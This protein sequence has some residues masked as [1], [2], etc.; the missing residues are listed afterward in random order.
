MTFH[1]SLINS[2]KFPVRFL[3][4]I[5][6]RDQR[7]V[8]GRVLS[9]ISRICGRDLTSLST[10]VAKDKIKYAVAPVS[11]KWRLGLAKEL[12]AARNSNEV[13][14]IGFTADEKEEMLRHVCVD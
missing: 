12:L 3:A 6:E 14:I 13:E 9:E 7:T 11:E 2:N 1:K 10:K 8:L 4:R 5:S